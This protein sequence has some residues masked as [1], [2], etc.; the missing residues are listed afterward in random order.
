MAAVRDT[1]RAHHSRS[2]LEQLARIRLQ[3]ERQERAEAIFHGLLLAVFA[4]ALGV[5]AVTFAGACTL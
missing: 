3:Q 1:T 2:V 5:F 4:L